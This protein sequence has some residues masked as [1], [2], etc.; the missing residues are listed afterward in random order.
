MLILTDAA[1]GA[2]KVDELTTF[3]FDHLVGER[4]K[5]SDPALRICGGRRGSPESG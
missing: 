4:S 1:G 2:E 3:P 5:L